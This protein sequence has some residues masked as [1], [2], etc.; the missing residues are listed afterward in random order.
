V[1]ALLASLSGDQS[2]PLVTGAAIPLRGTDDA[3]YVAHALPLGPQTREAHLPSSAVL[4]LFVRSATLGS[5]TSPELL[6]KEYRLTPTE[7]RVLL[8]IFDIGGAPG[9]ADALGI[10]ES[11]VKFH[12][13]RL[14]EKTGARRQAD[15]VKLVAGLSTPKIV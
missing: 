11:T 1:L 14:F 3:L 7:L 6:A 8:S 5:V 12:L 15:L 4:A 13:H 2:V 9:V 10:A